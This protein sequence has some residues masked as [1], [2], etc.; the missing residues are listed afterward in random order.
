MNCNSYP[1]PPSLIS[2]PG[3]G[4]ITIMY[5]YAL[6]AFS[7]FSR[8]F[9]TFLLKRYSE[10]YLSAFAEHMRMCR[11]QFTFSL[12]DVAMTVLHISAKVFEGDPITRLACDY[13]SGYYFKFTFFVLCSF[14]CFC[15]IITLNYRSIESR[16]GAR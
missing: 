7:F 16:R 9:F 14:L 10:Y 8:L 5:V 4:P 2:A 12:P 15:G 13:E 1:L 11:L 3:R 6:F